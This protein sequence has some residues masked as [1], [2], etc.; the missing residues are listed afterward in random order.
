MEAFMTAPPIGREG[1]IRHMGRVFQAFAGQSDHYDRK[2]E[3]ETAAMAY[4]RSFYPMGFVRQ[5]AAIMVSGSRRRTLRT[6]GVP[7]LVIHGADDALV[8]LA[9]GQDTAAAIPDAKLIV[10]EG[11][12]HGLS[13]PTLWDQIVEAIT[14][15]TKQVSA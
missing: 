6:V 1:Y 8:P 14:N 12:G 15:H 5:L 7:A 13:Y 4:D 2:L 3:E 11:L 10:V 9:H